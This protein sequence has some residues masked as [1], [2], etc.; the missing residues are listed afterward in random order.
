MNYRTL[1]I[2]FASS[3]YR[4]QFLKEKKSKKKIIKWKKERPMWREKNILKQRYWELNRIDS[5]NAHV[6]KKITLGK[7]EGGTQEDL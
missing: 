2:K 5:E 6:V 4:K 3:L 7:F 1:L